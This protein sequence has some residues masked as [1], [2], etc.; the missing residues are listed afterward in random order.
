MYLKNAYLVLIIGPDA[1]EPCNILLEKLVPWSSFRKDIYYVSL[2]L[3][4]YILKH[5][6]F[7]YS[8]CICHNKKI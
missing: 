7:I 4:P 8:Q 2:S 5:T 3:S 6:Y 1:M